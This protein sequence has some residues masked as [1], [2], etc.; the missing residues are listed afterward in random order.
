MKTIVQ[1][2]NCKAE[3]FIM[4][5]KLVFAME[6]KEEKAYCPSCKQVIHI[7]QTDGWYF[8]GV[9]SDEKEHVDNCVYPMS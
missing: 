7:G 2:P 5:V 1:C 6:K 4:E 8:V 3:F 9:N